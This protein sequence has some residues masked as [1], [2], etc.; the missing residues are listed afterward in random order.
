M[1]TVLRCSKEFLPPPS[2]VGWDIRRIAGL[3]VGVVLGVVVTGWS[4]V[5]GVEG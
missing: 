1:G 3:V 5:A 4:Q 2:Q